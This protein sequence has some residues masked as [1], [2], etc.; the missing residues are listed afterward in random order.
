MF[1]AE[2]GPDTCKSYGSADLRS[3]KA[4]EC[5]QLRSED[6]MSALLGTLLERA[7]RLACRRVQT[8]SRALFYALRR[9]N[10]V[11]NLDN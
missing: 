10:H 5:A 2:G 6:S 3:E 7:V 11:F 4:L 9:F 8:K 1:A